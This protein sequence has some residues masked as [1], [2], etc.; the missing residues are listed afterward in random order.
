MSPTCLPLQH[1]IFQM[2]GRAQKQHKGNTASNEDIL[3]LPTRALLGKTKRPE[4]ER[5]CKKGNAQEGSLEQPRS[6]AQ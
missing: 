5:A 4:T 3:S 2:Q 1:F 6:P